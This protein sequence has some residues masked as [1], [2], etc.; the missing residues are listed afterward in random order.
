[1][2]LSEIYQEILLT[3]NESPNNF[4]KLPDATHYSRGDNPICGDEIAVYVNV[5]GGKIAAI[6]FYGEGCAICRASGSLMT[7]QLKN[8]DVDEAVSFCKN[9]IKIL[10]DENVEVNEGDFGEL[11]VLFGVRNLPARLKCA[12][13]AW[14]AFLSAINDGAIQNAIPASCSKSCCSK[15][16]CCRNRM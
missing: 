9:F 10:S 13:L 15:R 6:S 3:H 7:E 14:H 16:S 4:G 8:M 1:M 12:T 2:D 5:A 11:R